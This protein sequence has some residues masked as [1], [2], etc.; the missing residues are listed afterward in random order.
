VTGS[1]ATGG[2]VFTITLNAATGEVTLDQV[3]AVVHDDPADPDESS[4]PAQLSA[5][6]LVTLTA[7]IIDG[8]GDTNTAT[9]D[10]GDAFKFED[11]GPTIDPSQ[12]TVPTLTVDD[13]DFT[14]NASASFAG[15]FTSG[16]FGNDGFKDTDN[17]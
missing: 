6:S 2:T 10:I 15:L 14:T 4:S 1:S 12:A 16:T 7:T 17:N 8:D 9:R 13:T 3:R 11:D 5:A